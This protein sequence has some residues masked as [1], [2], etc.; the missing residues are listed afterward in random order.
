MKSRVKFYYLVMGMGGC[1]IYYFNGKVIM[2]MS[3]CYYDA[4][5]VK[6][7]DQMGDFDH[8]YIFLR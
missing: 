8:Q 7:D 3:I 4:N 6:W 5:D 1:L 2:I